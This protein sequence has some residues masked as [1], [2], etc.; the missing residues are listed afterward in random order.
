M[1][2]LLTTL[3]NKVSYY[4]GDSAL[5]FSDVYLEP[6]YSDIVSRFGSQIDTST[7]VANN[8]PKINI[9]FISAGMDTVT[10]ND[11]ASI[12][13]LNGGMGEI[14]RNNSP[15]KQSDMIRIVKEKMRLIEKNP[16]IVSENATISDALSLLKIHMRGY[17]IVYRGNDYDGRF[18]GI[19]TSRDFLSGDPDTPIKKVMTPYESNENEKLI[20]ASVGTTLEDAVKIMRE[21]KI[22]KLP[23]IEKDGILFGVYTLKDYEHIKK[24]PKAA[25]DSQGRLV[26]GAAIG[27]HS[28]DIERAH[29]VVDA[30]ADILF[31]DIAHGHSI[32]SSEMIKK[33]KINEKIKTPIV[34]GNVATKEGV[35]FAY[36]IGA[37]GI[38]IGIG[39]GFVCKT[40][41]VTGTGIPQ[42]TAIL[43]AKEVLRGRSK[44]PPIIADGGV[45]EP[46][47]PP[48]AIAAG[49]DC[50]MWGSLWAGTDM[51]PGTIVRTNGFLQKRIRGMASKAVFEDR[52]K[53]GDS[54]TDSDL[55]APEG[56][57]VFTSFQGSTS[58][59]LKE[60]IGALR[61]AMSYT[62][63]H[64]IFELQKAKLIHVSMNG[65]NEQGRNLNA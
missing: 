20:T 2:T 60:Y 23:I 47:D 21:N 34:V 64:N 38:K 1:K 15:D 41:N 50:V 27:V 30:G 49:A 18:C 13:A 14:H 17:V 25:L 32:Y 11:M 33:L 31:L 36:D 52:K 46:G 5:A 63:S 8:A 48:K 53:M 39:P 59:L 62:G 22:E 3:K 26:V 9:P 7:K 44:A 55:Y 56:R 61:S 16:P 65:A 35:L 19:A 58:A 37:D 45:R 40:R 57:E 43:E 29:K 4:S 54:T 51:S 6:S 24:Y 10:E 28:I 12:F 42:I